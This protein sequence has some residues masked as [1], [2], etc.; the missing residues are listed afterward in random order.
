MT[1]VT[2]GIQARVGQFLDIFEPPLQKSQ[3]SPTQDRPAHDHDKYFYPSQLMLS[4]YDVIC[5][6]DFLCP[7]LSI[8][9][10]TTDVDS[11]KALST[12]S[13]VTVSS[14]L[15]SAS[16]GIGSS[17]ASSVAP[18]TSGTSLASSTIVGEDP[19]AE[20][21]VNGDVFP[22][23]PPK[24]HEPNTAVLEEKD[25][26]VIQL[27]EISNK[28]KEGLAPEEALDLT[29]SARE[30]IPIYIS[31][32]GMKLS[33]SPPVDE[34]N[35]QEKATPTKEKLLD[36]EI[37]RQYRTSLKEALISL[38]ASR[39][40]FYDVTLKTQSET[41]APSDIAYKLENLFETAMSICQDNLDFEKSFFWWRSVQLLRQISSNFPSK[42]FEKLLEDIVEDLR[43][44]Q[45]TQIKTTEKNL[46]W[47]YSLDIVHRNQ[48]IQLQTLGKRRNALRVKMWYV[49]DVRH[50]VPYEDA[51]NVT[52]AL[53]TMASSRTKQPSS[54][55]NWARHRLR[56]SFGNDR[57]DAQMLEVVA[58]HR[59]YGGLSKL[60]DEQVELTTR[61][62]TKNSIE[63]FCKG[64]ERIHR[65]CF[66]VQKCVNK[67]AGVNM[68]DSPVLWASRL[69]EREKSL[70]DARLSRSASYDLQ[71]RNSY[72]STDAW[73]QSRLTSSKPIPSQEASSSDSFGFNSSYTTS[74]PNTN[75]K[76]FNP[77]GIYP[78]TALND[79][80]TFKSSSTFTSFAHPPILQN[81][82][83]L[84]YGA[85]VSEDAIT[86]KK[87]FAQ[88]VKKTLHSLV[89]SDIGYLL[90]TRGSETDTWIN[91]QTH[92]TTQAEQI[93]MESEFKLKVNY[94]KHEGDKI[95]QQPQS[96]VPLFTNDQNLLHAEVLP[97]QDPH[98]I[99]TF[100]PAH[101]SP[102]PYINSYKMLLDRFSYSPDP[103]IK[104]QTLTELESLA[105]SSSYKNFT[106]RSQ[107]AATALNRNSDPAS[108]NPTSGRSI[109]IPRTK[110][111]SLEEV[112]ANC[113]E[114][115]AGTL[116]SH[117]NGR[118]N[119]S[120][121]PLPNTD[122][123]I[124]ALFEIFQDPSLRP[125]TLFRDL[126]YIAAFIPP[127]IL[128]Q[129]PQGKAFWDAGLAALALKEDICSAMI[130][131]ATQITTYHISPPAPNPDVNLAN[132]TL[133]DAARLWLITAKEGSPVAARELGLF[134]LTHPELLPRITLPFSKAKDVFRTAMGGD[135]GGGGGGGLL[136][137]AGGGKGGAVGLETGGLDALT[138]AVVFHWM[139]TAANGGDRDARAFLREMGELSSGK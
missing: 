80:S 46:L 90:W 85:P 100:D 7:N 55:S 38:M 35:T 129:T 135:Q 16:V 126:Q 63:N 97:P 39:N 120:A 130:T 83:S 111:T 133:R 12:A 78:S 72:V 29:Q 11:G 42:D 99:N 66:E 89:I 10:T 58:A 5:L 34:F 93:A 50:S 73:N 2:P 107:A 15:T 67:L 45:E 22:I 122:S 59:D 1:I 110:A 84:G 40:F 77:S 86:A 57:S 31:D 92:E 134:Y 118:R 102:F 117:M 17:I 52:R 76:F 13:S 25:C 108:T 119:H 131:R 74:Y 62:L 24:G 69:F 136:G 68:L 91:L 70:F 116:T 106:P 28:I 79:Q 49:S 54:L 26:S 33:L 21:H 48:K 138:F 41:A 121:P 60:A 6:M 56:N 18:S 8:S 123:S 112:I 88:E 94:D 32:S 113:T 65:F 3:V 9:P 104:L 128:D 71:H 109:K 127:S 61:W 44:S 75:S 30:W 4:S 53:R 105:L 115:R 27:R 36:S 139:E 82:G 96:P 20:S 114:R 43:S 125:R 37:H 124:S 101:L 87:A 47:R 64:E 98:L 19:S 51:M 95:S 81:T 103:Y 132:T 23:S 137:G 14:T